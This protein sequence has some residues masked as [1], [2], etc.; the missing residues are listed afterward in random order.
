MVIEINTFI[1]VVVHIL[2]SAAYVFTIT[3]IAYAAEDA[4]D[5]DEANT[6]SIII[7]LIILLQA[8]FWYRG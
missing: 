1:E 7:I 4:N 2:L 5:S 6:F 8:Y 3:V